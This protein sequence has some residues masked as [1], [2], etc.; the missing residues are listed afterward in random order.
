M[1]SHAPGEHPVH[2]LF[3]EL[4]TL[5]Y[6]SSMLA[7][8][9]LLPGTGFFPGGPGLWGITAENALPALPVGKVMIVGQ[10][11]DCEAGYQKSLAQG[12]ENQRQVATQSPALMLSLGI[13]VPPFLAPLARQLSPWAKCASFSDIDTHG[14]P[15]I[16]NACFHGAHDVVTTVV[17]LTHPCL[18][19]LYIRHR[20]YNGYSGD[21]AEVH[22]L[23][24]A[25][26]AAAKT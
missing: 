16:H 3:A 10:D 13:Q 9:Q 5:A 4:S 8:P 21:E 11:F 25:L 18:R 24:D 26:R 20:R 12:C 6:P 23:G 19:H 7:V 22:L 15:L 1:T 17:S 2:R 14:A